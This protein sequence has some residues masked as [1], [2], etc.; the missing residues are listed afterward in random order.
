MTRAQAIAA[1]NAKLSVL[2][3]ERVQTVADIV[4]DLAAAGD[5]PRELTARELALVEQSKQDFAAGRVVTP[6]DYRAE[7]DAFLQ[8]R[9]AKH[10][11][12]T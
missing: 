11:Q 5:L 6:D 2:D 3:D 9:R 8:D 12:K 10:S 1:I 7:M 4:S